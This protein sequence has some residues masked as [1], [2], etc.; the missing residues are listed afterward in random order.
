MK[1]WTEPEAKNLSI[2]PK[3]FFLGFNFSSGFQ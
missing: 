2:T 3:W 1:G